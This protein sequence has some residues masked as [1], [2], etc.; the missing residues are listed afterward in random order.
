MTGKRRSPPNAS[1]RT[2]ASAQL[3]RITKN[4]VLAGVGLAGD[5]AKHPDYGKLRQLA[6]DLRTIVRKL[7][8][9]GGHVGLQLEAAALHELITRVCVQAPAP[10]LGR[11]TAEVGSVGRRRH[12]TPDGKVKHK[13]GSAHP[14]ISGVSVHAVSGGLPE[15][16]K[17]R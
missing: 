1:A 16:G 11:N 17:R 6:A 2:P 14:E 7:Q 15:S 4:A 10:P 5:G 3:E 12:R 8:R 9:E 13:K